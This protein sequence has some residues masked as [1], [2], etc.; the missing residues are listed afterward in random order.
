MEIII[1]VS[2]PEE[3]DKAVAN[4]LQS[5]QTISTKPAALVI[6]LADSREVETTISG[7]AS[8]SC[9]QR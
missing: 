8:V 9:T 5:G 3:S 4:A 1:E 6:A 2:G 7:T